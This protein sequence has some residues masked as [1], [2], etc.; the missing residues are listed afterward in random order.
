MATTQTVER[1]PRVTR[2]TQTVEQPDLLR[3]SVSVFSGQK[4]RY[5]YW[6]QRSEQLNHELSV[7]KL[8]ID[9]MLSDLVAQIDALTQS[10]T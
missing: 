10:A 9:N 8:E 3:N 2:T 5:E 7:A 6:S 4:E 1:I